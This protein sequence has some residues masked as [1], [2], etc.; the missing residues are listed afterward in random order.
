MWLSDIMP[1]KV[2]HIHH[3]EILTLIGIQIT[4]RCTNSGS[5]TEPLQTCISFQVQKLLL[6]ATIL[7]H[8][9]HS[10]PTTSL[11]VNV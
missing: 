6:L 10:T 7:H 1:D 5:M 3:F 9:I 4:V 2:F 11:T 8:V